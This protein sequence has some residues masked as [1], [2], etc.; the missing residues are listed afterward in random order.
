MDESR[1]L[2]ACKLRDEGKYTEASHEFLQLAE[3]EADPLE[4]AGAL[5]YAANTL[6]ISGQL[7]A[8]TSNL[9]EAQALMEGYP[10]PAAGEKF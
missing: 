6:E 8:A 5:L 2:N 4:K 10:N 3:T 9:S 1:F 7:E